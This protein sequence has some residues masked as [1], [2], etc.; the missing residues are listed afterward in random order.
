MCFFTTLNRMLAATYEDL[1]NSEI[2]WILVGSGATLLQGVNLSPG[3]IDVLMQT[4]GGVYVFAR[5]MEEFTP[6]DCPVHHADDP[7]QW[8]SSRNLP[9]LADEPNSQEAVWTFGRWYIDGFKVE[10]SHIE[11][12]A[13]YLGTKDDDAGLWEAGPEVWPHV[14]RVAWEGYDIPVVPLEIQLHTNMKRSLEDRV[15]KIVEV[16]RTRGYDRNLINLGLTADEKTRLAG[17]LDP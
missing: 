7:D 14:N 11:P 4:P 15:Q 16:F 3:D 8:Y 17:L 12:P 1:R 9:V 10:V 5:S 6:E 13:D 2:R